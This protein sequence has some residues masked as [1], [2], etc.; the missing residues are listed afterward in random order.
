MNQI[1]LETKVLKNNGIFV[2]VDISGKSLFVRSASLGEIGFQDTDTRKERFRPPSRYLIDKDLFNELFSTAE[3]LRAITY[4]YATDIEIFRPYRWIP[5]Q[6]YEEWKREWDEIKSQCIEILDKKILANYDDLRKKA[7]EDFRKSFEESF[8]QL[9]NQGRKQIVVDG[10]TYVNRNDFVEAMTRR[11]MERFPT[12]DQIRQEVR[13]EYK[14]A[15]FT[16]DLD[17]EREWAEIEAKNLKNREQ[18][19]KINAIRQAELEHVRK[20]LAE[21]KSPLVKVVESLREKILAD[22]ET[23]LQSVKKNGFLREDIRSRGESLLQFYELLA[24]VDDRK[25]REK[26]VEMDR[27]LKNEPPKSR[28]R[29]FTKQIEKQLT[30]IVNLAHEEIDE[31]EVRDSSNFLLF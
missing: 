6:A 24:V 20:Q 7:E 14:V 3:K 30:E 4:K 25:L 12:P 10:V 5:F 11:A 8:R 17:V 1:F 16:V 26:L 2:D 29:Q 19:A 15:T 27:L 22:V 23:M 18:A 21:M 9:K 13:F 31:S 28:D